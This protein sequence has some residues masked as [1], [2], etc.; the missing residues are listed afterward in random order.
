MERDQS[1]W[2]KRDGRRNVSL[3]GAAY[4]EDGRSHRVLV[5]NIAYN[6]CHLICEGS[7]GVGETLKLIV[8]GMGTVNAQVRWTKEERAG[9]RFLIENNVTAQ[10]Q[11]R[12]RLGV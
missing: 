8:P 9:L 4:R 11:R 7:L 5:T 12:A 2:R 3:G 6:G 10:D 1:E